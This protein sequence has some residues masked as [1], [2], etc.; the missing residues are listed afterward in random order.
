MAQRRV[1]RTPDP[2]EALDVFGF[3]GEREEGLR[4]ELDPQGQGI[5][6]AFLEPD[7]ELAAAGT[8]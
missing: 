7:A 3:E 2:G 8:D 1:E 5:L 6:R 4:L